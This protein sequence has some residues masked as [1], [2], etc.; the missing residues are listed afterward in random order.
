MVLDARE[1][2]D[3]SAEHPELTDPEERMFAAHMLARENALTKIFGPTEPPD[4]I[5]SPS[6][7]ELVA[8][9]PG[10]GVHQYPPR[11]TRRTWHYVTHGLSQPFDEADAEEFA[12]DPDSASGFGVEFVISTPEPCTWAPDVLI[13]LVKYLLLDEDAR[14]IEPGHRFACEVEGLVT[15]LDHMLAIMS[16]EYECQLV[17]PGGHCTLVHLVGTTEAEV[18]QARE[19]GGMDGSLI[20][21]DVLVSAG[22]GCTTDPTRKSLTERSDFL[23]MWEQARIDLETDDDGDDDDDDDDD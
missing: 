19:H 4:Q 21:F 20:L 10:G 13:G 18:D 3:V 5:L 22:V 12:T 14:A 23:E 8:N 9:W 17:L 7:P 6:D 1:L 16:P 2:P 15:E 11:G